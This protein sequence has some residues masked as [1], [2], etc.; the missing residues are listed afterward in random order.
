MQVTVI[1]GTQDWRVHVKG[2]LEAANLALGR[3]GIHRPFSNVNITRGV[4]TATVAADRDQL[5]RW[6]MSQHDLGPGTLLFYMR[7]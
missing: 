6:W 4:L 7:P 2:P 1:P 5:H 3:A